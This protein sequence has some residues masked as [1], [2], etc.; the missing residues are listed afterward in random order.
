[1]NP[2]TPLHVPVQ[3]GESFSSWLH[4]LAAR[5]RLGLADLNAAFGLTAGTLTKLPQDLDRDGIT[6]AAVDQMSAATRIPSA[7]I[8]GTWT[9][10]RSYARSVEG[11]M[12]PVRERVLTPAA[13]SRYC[14]H[15]LRNRP[16]W[17]AAWR[18]PWLLACPQHLCQLPQSCSR[19]GGA[20]RARRRCRNLPHW[21]CDSDTDCE[22]DLRDAPADAA[23][24]RFLEAQQQLLTTAGWAAVPADIDRLLDVLCLAAD[25]HP[26][27][28]RAPVL[29]T[30]P[31]QFMTAI[32]TAIAHL[33]DPDL[34]RSYLSGRVGPRTF[35]RSG[36]PLPPRVHCATPALLARYATA[37]DPQLPTATRLRW[38]TTTAPITP[39]DDRTVLEARRRSV[40]PLL[41]ADWALRTRPPGA[42]RFSLHRWQSTAARLVLLPG[43]PDLPTDAEDRRWHTDVEHSLRAAGTAAQRT[44]IVRCLTELAASLDR[45]G[46]PIDYPRR[47]QLAASPQILQ[48]DRWAQ[49]CRTARIRNSSS[50]LRLAR[51]WIWTTLTG[52]SP[53]NTPAPLRTGS[54]GEFSA[55]RTFSALLPAP[56]AAALT[57]IAQEVLAAAGVDEP[58]TWTPPLTWASAAG[59]REIT[60][61]DRPPELHRRTG[62]SAKQAAAG[63]GIDRDYVH[64]LA[65]QNRR[66]VPPRRLP[67]PKADPPTLDAAALRELHVTRRMSVKAIAEQTGVR[68][69]RVRRLITQHRI[70]RLRP[71]PPAVDPAWL[72]REY[73]DN[74][75]TM[76]DL[77]DE[78]GIGPN[79]MARVARAAALEIRARGGQPRRHGR[80]GNTPRL[81]DALQLPHGE[82]LVV[83]F[84][85][86]ARSRSLSGAARRLGVQPGAVINDLQRLERGLGTVLIRRG[87]PRS[88]QQPTPAGRHLLAQADTRL[89]AAP[90]RSTPLPPMLA[91]C[92][93]G[94]H[95]VERLDRL[96]T[97]AASPT[98]ADA[99]KTLGVFNSTLHAQIRVLEGRSRRTLL[100]TASGR[101]NT[102]TTAAGAELLAQFAQHR[103]MW[104]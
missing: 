88:P 73:T 68:P 36:S 46:A 24:P 77:A 44:A 100:G 61:T 42:G 1:M 29:H 91:T 37:A 89:G 86:A 90:Q 30:R 15:C 75:R 19:C 28:R 69:E 66:P 82:R 96:A 95:D 72:K 38:R 97:I 92:I 6:A 39:A 40:P 84:Q 14:P 17:S 93:D 9:S 31:A 25:I 60:P 57:T 62:W 5:H 58:L 103:Q 85:T 65:E 83:H 56:A 32:V 16:A 21:A 2:P 49:I 18:L 34:F 78:L 63:L 98:I 35:I 11:K 81:D 48:P 52:D 27:R 80:S 22:A 101:R 45:Y 43:N 64:W 79:V 47:H 23:P 74:G 12:R 99:A 55:F 10:L 7:D 71:A 54:A 53:A 104:P 102:R 50:S 3:P 94:P 20:Q 67:T 87:T 41:W 13:Q 51:S 59:L 33:D 70:P 26:D 76:R 4:R 8:A